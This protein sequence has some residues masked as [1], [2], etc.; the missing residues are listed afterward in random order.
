MEKK[1]VYSTYEDRVHIERCDVMRKREMHT[2]R[3]V[4]FLSPT[5]LHEAEG[6]RK[7]EERKRAKKSL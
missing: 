6:E 2:N 4:L 7:R 3:N 1:Q 5:T